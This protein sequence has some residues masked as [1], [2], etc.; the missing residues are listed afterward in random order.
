MF[1]FS[2]LCTIEMRHRPI[3]P[4]RQRR[5][6]EILYLCIKNYN[7]NKNIWRSN[8]VIK[9]IL[10]LCAHR[11]PTRWHMWMMRFDAVYVRFSTY[12]RPSLSRRFR[13]AHTK[14]FFCYLCRSFVRS[15]TFT[16]TKPTVATVG[17]SIS[18]FKYDSTQAIQ[19]M[20]QNNNNKNEITYWRESMHLWHYMSFFRQMFA[21]THV[22]HYSVSMLQ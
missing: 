10:L 13:F 15:F 3:M 21:D 8:I 16:E 7:N 20:E 6:M 14:F 18:I 9:E 11:W 19:R 12:S 1:H 2:T 22:R 4:S 5:L 17:N